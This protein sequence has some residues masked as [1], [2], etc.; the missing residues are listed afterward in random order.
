M[1]VISALS[2]PEERTTRTLLAEG[3]LIIR[4]P[5]WGEK[6]PLPTAP[7]C[8]RACFSERKHAVVTPRSVFMK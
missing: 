7:A 8:G 4:A 3:T 6:L 2:D 5:T 1:S